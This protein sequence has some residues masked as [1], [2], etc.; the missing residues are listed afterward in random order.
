MIG[1]FAAVAAR[2]MESIQLILEVE[3]VAYSCDRGLQVYDKGKC[4]GM[5]SERKP[6]EFD[7]YDWS[8]NSEFETLPRTRVRTEP[9]T[10][11]QPCLS[12]LHDCLRSHID[13]PLQDAL[14]SCVRIQ[15]HGQPWMPVPR[16]FCRHGG[17]RVRHDSND[18]RLHD[19]HLGIHLG[20]AI[21]SDRFLAIVR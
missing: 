14:P 5:S 20:Q 1:R 16:P 13:R 9:Y 4:R 8:S 3:P 12:G 2:Y 10:A 6:A 7:L 17:P 18:R 21:P 11:R 19:V 15:P